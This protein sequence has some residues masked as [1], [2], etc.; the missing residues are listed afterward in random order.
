MRHGEGCIP[1]QP[2][3]QTLRLDRASHASVD[4]DV[5]RLYRSVLNVSLNGRP[6]LVIPRTVKSHGHQPR[7]SL[8]ASE[9][10]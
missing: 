3:L 9:H 8:G 10:V 5:L 6:A 1:A 2:P 4:N 7:R